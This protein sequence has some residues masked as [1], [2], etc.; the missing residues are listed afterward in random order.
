MTRV[1]VLLLASLLHHVYSAPGNL[2]T[3]EIPFTITPAVVKTPVTLAKTVAAVPSAAAVAVAGPAVTPVVQRIESYSS[4]E[5]SN[6]EIR[7]LLRSLLFEL[8]SA[9]SLPSSRVTLSSPATLSTYGPPSQLLD[10]YSA[11]PRDTYTDPS[12]P[13]YPESFDVNRNKPEKVIVESP[14]Y[15][16]S[17]AVAPPVKEIVRTVYQPV[18]VPVQVAQPEVLTVSQP[19]VTAVPTAIRTGASAVAISTIHH[20]PAYKLQQEYGLPVVQQVQQVATLTAPVAA[21]SAALV[22]SSAGGYG[23]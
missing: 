1:A 16:S 21:T 8:R 13:S 20:Q 2:P 19:Y 15:A 3:V 11:P 18:Y 12:A 10:S 7:D 9:S 5:S 17:I 22:E 4:G 6:A 23:K 14:V